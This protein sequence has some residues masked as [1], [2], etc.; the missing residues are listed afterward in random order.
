MITNE[1]KIEYMKEQ[2][3]EDWEILRK[4]CYKTG[5]YEPI[6]SLLHQLIEYEWGIE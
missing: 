3:L 1:R 6:D 4:Y 2:I 5:N